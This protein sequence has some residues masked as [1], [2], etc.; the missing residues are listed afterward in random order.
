[1]E[2]LEGVIPPESAPSCVVAYPDIV[3]VK[4][5]YLQVARRTRAQNARSPPRTEGAALARRGGENGGGDPKTPELKS[6]GPTGTTLQSLSSR[7]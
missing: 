7:D 4:R 6:A 3:L 1:M 5:R 2:M